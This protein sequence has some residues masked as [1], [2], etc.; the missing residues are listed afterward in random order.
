MKWSRLAGPFENRP[1]IV[2]FLNVNKMA[3]HL[4]TG[5]KKC[6]ENDHSKTGQSGIWL[7]T[8]LSSISISTN[9]VQIVFYEKEMV[10][11]VQLSINCRLGCFRKKIFELTASF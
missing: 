6:P 11:H 9:Y 7:F 4:K 2:R 10:Q 3:D 1:K 5:P 8:V